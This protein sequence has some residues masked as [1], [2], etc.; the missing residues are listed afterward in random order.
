MNIEVVGPNQ[1]RFLDDAVPPYLNSH[2]KKDSK[3]ESS[4]NSITQCQSEPSGSIS[5]DGQLD[6]EQAEDQQREVST[7]VDMG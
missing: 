5:N 2:A 7:D 1:L 4:G 6:E 3:L